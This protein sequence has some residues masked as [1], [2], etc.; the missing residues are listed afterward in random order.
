MNN[1]VFVIITGAAR[2]SKKQAQKLAEQNRE[3]RKRI[4]IKT[5]SAPSHTPEKSVSRTPSRTP[6]LMVSR[7]QRISKKQRL[8]NTPSVSE[9]TTSTNDSPTSEKT[10]V[11]GQ[12]MVRLYITLYSMNE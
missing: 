6:D 7:Q 1:N 5:S 10:D 2:L 9:V 4:E 12:E 3:K 11:S 8:L